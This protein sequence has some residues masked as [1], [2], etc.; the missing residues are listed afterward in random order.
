MGSTQEEEAARS[1]R[2]LE[3][4]MVARGEKCPLAKGVGVGVGG[5]AH[6]RDDGVAVVPIDTLGA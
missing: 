3:K 1:L 2:A 6:M 4:K 5:V